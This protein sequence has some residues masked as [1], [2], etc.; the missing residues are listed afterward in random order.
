MVDKCLPHGFVS[1]RVKRRGVLQI[2]RQESAKLSGTETEVKGSHV[3]RLSD[4]SYSCHGSRNTE[5]PAR[6][7]P[8]C[9][10]SIAYMGQ[11]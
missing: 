8:Q 7:L 3:G 10:I 5:S 9:E 11:A 2:A 1:P 6:I 4:T